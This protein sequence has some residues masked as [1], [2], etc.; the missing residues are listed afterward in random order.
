MPT[1]AGFL[2]TG[3]MCEGQKNPR[4][5]PIISQLTKTAVGTGVLTRA[6]RNSPTK[7]EI[8]LVFF[9]IQFACFNHP[10]SSTPGASRARHRAHGVIRY[11]CSQLKPFGSW[12]MLLQHRT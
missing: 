5:V 9:L 11:T 10:S 3:S 7:N 6:S 8:V 1:E 4:V 12:M 2:A